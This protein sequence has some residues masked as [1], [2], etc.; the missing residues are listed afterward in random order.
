MVCFNFNFFPSLKDKIIIL[1]IHFL[2]F[3]LLSDFH[4]NIA[5]N[6]AVPP[7]AFNLGIIPNVFF[8]TKLLL[9][10]IPIIL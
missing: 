6:L 3:S 4:L 1:I 9:Y 8:L 5:S 10:S 7:I 2:I